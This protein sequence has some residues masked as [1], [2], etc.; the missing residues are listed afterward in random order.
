MSKIVL[1]RFGNRPPLQIR[2]EVD[3]PYHLFKVREQGG[4]AC[5]WCPAFGIAIGD[6][7]LCE[8]PAA[9]K[10]LWTCMQGHHRPRSIMQGTGSHKGRPGSDLEKQV[11]FGLQSDDHSRFEN[12][13]YLYSRDSA[14]SI[15]WIKGDS[16]LSPLR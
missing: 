3:V 10:G 7:L 4:W 6:W 16:N 5:P 2:L 8:Y 1:S 12:E 14:C 11:R 9:V 13:Q 15:I